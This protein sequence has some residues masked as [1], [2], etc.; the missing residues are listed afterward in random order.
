MTVTLR[1]AVLAW[2]RLTADFRM[3]PSVLVIGAQRSGTTTLFRLLEAHPNL[4]R[5]TLVKGTGY[6]DDRYAHGARWY[7]AHFPL[8]VTA[9]W[10][11]RGGPAHT[12]ECSG[13][14]LF[15]PLAAGRIA[16]DLPGVQVVVL[17]RDPVE[18]AC[19]AYRHEL[20]R[21]FE[22]KS[23]EEALML[24]PFRTAGEGDRLAAEPDYRSFAHRH[25]AYLQRSDYAPQ[26]QR[27]VDALGADRVHVVEADEFFA[28][29]VTQFLA[30]Q[31][32]LGLPE[33]EPGEVGHW[34]A[35]PG[36]SLSPARR[37]ELMHHFE[38]SDARLAA[39]LGRTPSWRR[40]RVAS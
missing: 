7:A 12:F 24:E 10:L 27:F 29:P 32:S 28:D 30:L 3:T 4:V 33:W 18:R 11:A 38:R 19:S 40:A 20:A 16:R 25:H 17:V 23:F 13:Y 9:R 31:R 36:R 26:I 15:H 14:Y 21:G 8:R 37:A 35:R 6:F 34:N 22:T 2:G 39:L 1:G 5:P